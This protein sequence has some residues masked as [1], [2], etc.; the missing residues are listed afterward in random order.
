LPSASAGQASPPSHFQAANAEI[1]VAGTES[2]AT[3]AGSWKLCRQATSQSSGAAVPSV[4]SLCGE[5]PAS[6]SWMSLCASSEE[7]SIALNT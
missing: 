5:Q 4:A 2:S 1:T 7:P 3:G 6:A